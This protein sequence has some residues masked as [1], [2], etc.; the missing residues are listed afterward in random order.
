[1]TRLRL[2]KDDPLRDMMTGIRNLPWPDKLSSDFVFSY[3]DFCQSI[4]F[5]T[6]FRRQ[7]KFK[8]DFIFHYTSC[9]TFQRLIAPGG[10]L[11]MTRFDE[12]NDDSEFEYGWQQVMGELEWRY[13]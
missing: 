2:R 11:L 6:L 5:D 9:E 4:K 7:G 3:G 8:G 10:D 1:M 13:G 12:L